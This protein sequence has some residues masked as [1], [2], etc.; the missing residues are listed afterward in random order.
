[1]AGKAA[2]LVDWDNL[3]GALLQTDYGHHVTEPSSLLGRLA[4]VARSEAL[5]WDPKHSLDYVG[6]AAQTSGLA[7]NTA[8]PKAVADL[9]ANLLFSA[10]AKQAVDVRLAAEALTLQLKEGYSLFFLVT[11]DIDYVELASSLVENDGECLMWQVPTWHLSPLSRAYEPKA[12]VIELLGLDKR[13]P[14]AQDDLLLF[15]LSCQR[16]VDEGFALSSYARSTERL[17]RMLPDLDI[18][19]NWAR[20]QSE[21]WLV[22]MGLARRLGYENAELVTALTLVDH[23]LATVRQQRGGASAQQLKRVLAEH[24]LYKFEE[25]GDLPSLMHQAGYLIREGQRYLVE[26]LSDLGSLRTLRALALCIWATEEEHPAWNAV[27]GGLIARMWPRYVSPGRKSSVQLELLEIEGSR[28]LQRG[29]AARIVR[30][31]KKGFIVDRAHPIVE[32][33]VTSVKALVRV[34]DDV[35]GGKDAADVRDVIKYLGDLEGSPFGLTEEDV[36]FWLRLLAAQRLILW[37]KGKIRLRSARFSRVQNVLRSVDEETEP[38][39]AP[40]ADYYSCFISYSHSDGLFARRLYKGL[41]ERGVPCWLDERE[42]LPGD[43]IDEKVDR[44]VREW[45]KFL[46]CCSKAS[47][48]SWWVLNE[49]EIALAKERELT[50]KRGHEVN[51]LIPLNLDGYLLGGEW[52]SGK[53]R[54]ILRRLAADFTGWRDSRVKFDRELERVVRAL[55]LEGQEGPSAP[56]SRL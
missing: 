11:A 46:L 40:D 20:A 17:G 4:E 56:E 14:A 26:R 19:A 10:S 23:L 42:L 1:M 36:R 49:V 50:G 28:L 38:P 48:N 52:E 53:K 16:L 3:K 45:D 43:P 7:K 22:G 13:L 44:A 27:S 21:T 8:L 9:S 35:T 2:L 54:Q 5:G 55:R 6:V 33:V 37:S 15:V 51:L 25:Y 32:H 31:R 30:R 29:I 18:E 24:P 47:L 39:R 12:N 34:V 41:K